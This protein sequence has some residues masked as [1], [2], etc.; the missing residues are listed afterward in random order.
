[1]N[2]GRAP[3]PDFDSNRYERP[4]KKWVCG[5]AK[6]GCPCRIGPSP[7]G[8]CRATTECT[9]RLILK[10]GE[11]K[12]TWACTRPADWGGPCGA[13][14][15]PDGK[16]CKAIEKCKP[17]RT[18]RSRRGLV[19]AAAVAGSL[20]ILLIGLSG[21]R[22]D[23]FINPSPLSRQ[24]SGAEFAHMAAAAG[25]GQGCVL[26]HTEANGDLARLAMAALASSKGSLSFGV[27]AGSH[28]KDFSRMDHSCVAC[29]MAQSFHQ[30]DVAKDTACSVCHMEHRG[31]GSMA[32]VTTRGCVDCHG[33]PG[34]MALARERS[35]ALPAVMFT[36]QRGQGRL[37]HETAR[38]AEGF[39]EVITA[40]AV[41]HLEFR[42]L[43]DKSPDTNT[44][45]FNHKLHLL[46]PDIPLVNGRRLECA[47]CHRQDA[48]GAYMAKVSFEQSCR[49]CHGLEF[50]AETPGMKLP[51]GDPTFARN[52]LR[53]L[54]VQYADFASR[55]LGVTGGAQVD[56]FV[57][58]HIESLRRREHT[59]EELERRVFLGS[60]PSQRGPGASERAALTSCA[61]C[62]EVS[63][64]DNTV[65]RV[66]A[67]AAPD[68]WLP[69]ASFNHAPH[70]TM[71][72][73]E[74]HAAAASELTS[75]VILPTQ[76]SCVRCHSPKGG[77]VDSCTSCHVYHNPPP[78]FTRN[79]VTASAQ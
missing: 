65:P 6:D 38:P 51:H 61:L 26:C 39:T 33:S 63:W 46:G 42:V 18:L 12:G 76:A 59:G 66:T 19:T 34:E 14:P 41:D 57:R 50:D 48:T 28:P 3:T 1:V 75:D 22:R 55:V 45:R 44:L 73:N 69:G 64:R 4:N 20:G 53:S 27:I 43:R 78:L 9:P 7:S 29:H 32:E 8:E 72:C 74:C 5:N 17:E 23:T 40:F 24:H 30:A 25:G 68:R 37:L 49:T 52:Y 35:L 47:D 31:E 60:G 16:C 62:H 77:A 79:R 70:T 71:A 54:P 58:R 67:P 11:E 15:G 21:S 13:G 36:R 56:A 10:P 2:E